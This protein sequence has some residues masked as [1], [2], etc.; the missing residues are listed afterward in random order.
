[1]RAQPTDTR[2]FDLL[3][4]AALTELGIVVGAIAVA[5]VLSVALTV[6]AARLT[7]RTISDLDDLVIAELRA[8]IFL[9]LGSVAVWLSIAHL[10][11][12]GRI[13]GL[14]LSL[15]GTVVA[16]VVG[17]RLFRVAR[18]VILALSRPERR[19]LRLSPRLVPLAEYASQIALWLGTLYA[20]AAAW[21]LETTLLASSAG[22]FG[23]ALGLAADAPLG[24]VIAGLF[25]AADRPCQLGDF[26][27]FPDGTRGQVTHIGLRSVRVLTLDGV[28]LNLP[29]ALVSGSRV[30]NE[31]AGDDPAIRLATRFIL[32]QGVAL[33]RVRE[34]VAGMPALPGVDAA[35]RPELWVL[36]LDE[37]GVH[38]AA[39]FWITE[40]SRRLPATDAVNTWLYGQLTAAGV[41][42]AV[43]QHVV[44]VDRIPPALAALVEP[45]R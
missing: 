27:A 6:G 39:L 2:A 29:N 31:T 14:L 25:I 26:L 22:L 1:M 41:A 7:A 30:V 35:R 4:S 9:G 33:E 21:G 15:L 3:S 20:I 43:R 13:E 36:A 17:R 38:V 5:Y 37:R 23:L 45:S 8:P 44:H 12:P 40:P 32:H 34:V 42:F 24:N 18:H 10:H 28:E 11:L 19:R 16:V